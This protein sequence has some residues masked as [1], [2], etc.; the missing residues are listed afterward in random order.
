M[1]NLF[2]S[3]FNSLF[4]S[5]SRNDSLDNPISLERLENHLRSNYSNPNHILPLKSEDSLI[6]NYN[7]FIQSPEGGTK[8]L[9]IIDN[10]LPLNKELYFDIISRMRLK[11]STLT[12]TGIFDPDLLDLLNRFQDL[13]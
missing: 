7:F 8:I 6:D 9:K 11:N 5:Q 10:P 4:I 13:L 1:F 3:C 2:G 12:S